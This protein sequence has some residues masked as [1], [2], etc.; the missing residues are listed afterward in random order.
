MVQSGLYDG[1]ASETF[2]NYGVQAVPM[3]FLIDRA[4][5]LHP[6]ESMAGLSEQVEKLL[7]ER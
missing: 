7:A 2:Q 5:I 3:L 4:G 6:V 1:W